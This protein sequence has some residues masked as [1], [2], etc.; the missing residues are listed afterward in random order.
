MNI[1]LFDTGLLDSNTYVVWGESKNALIVDCGVRTSEVLSF[2]KENNITVKHIVLTHGHYDHVDH[3]GEYLDTFKDATA[4]CHREDLKVLL[5]PEANVSRLFTREKRAYSYN[6]TFLSEGDTLTIDDGLSFKVLN[7]P[8]H[9]PGSICLYN[10][11]EGVLFTG[12]VV[13]SGGWGRTDFLYGSPED[14][15]ASLSRIYKLDKLT[16]V[17]PGHYEPVQLYQIFRY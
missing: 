7:L 11:N 15:N 14:M 16:K 1:K 10:E 8:G 13:S 9:T 2:V 17:Y 6:Y 5:D 12:D 3:I 4:Y